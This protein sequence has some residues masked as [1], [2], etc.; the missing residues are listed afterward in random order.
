MAK[1]LYL[2]LEAPLQSWGERS[3]W[4]DRDTGP[5]PT[6]SAVIGLI[7]CA[8]GRSD[9]T[10]IRR[11]SLSTRMGVRIDASGTEIRDFYTIGVG[12]DV[13]QGPLRQAEDGKLKNKNKPP[14]HKWYLADASFLVALQPLPSDDDGLIDEMA[15]ALQHP[16]WVI[17]L[18]R[19]CCP[20]G[21][22]VYAGV[23]EC[24]DLEIA[25]AYGPWTDPVLFPKPTDALLMTETECARQ[26]ADAE[27]QDVLT[28]RRFRTF[29]RRYTRTVQIRLSAE[30]KKEA[31]DG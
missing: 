6:K 11:W 18:G 26:D 14:G 5:I 28:S 13:G 25:L 24:D 31:A 21:R 3:R 4:V 27:R 10:T 9:D 22:P 1:T 7:A 20:P 23:H 30:E 12:Y 8:A 29:E 17:Y 15:W 2:R 19:K 16:K